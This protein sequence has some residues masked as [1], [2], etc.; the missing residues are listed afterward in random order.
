VSSTIGVSGRVLRAFAMPRDEAGAG[1]AGLD[2]FIHD[3]SRLAICVALLNC[4]KADFASLRALTGLTAGN[5][6]FHLTRLKEADLVTVDRRL[7]GTSTRT[8]VALTPAGR[9]RV[10]AHWEALDRL[11]RPAQ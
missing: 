3:P 2:R 5:L 10:L 11:R 8:D 6:S 9:R 7:V 4:E 1:P